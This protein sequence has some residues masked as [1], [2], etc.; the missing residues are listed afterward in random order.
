MEYV[1][2]EDVEGIGTYVDQIAAPSSLL[3]LPML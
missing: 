3:H 2:Y 1:V